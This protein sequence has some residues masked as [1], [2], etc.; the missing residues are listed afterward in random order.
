MSR[1]G[2]GREKN[3]SPELKFSPP[4]GKI[5]ENL[6]KFDNSGNGNEK[7]GNW[8]SIGDS[9]RSGLKFITAIMATVPRMMDESERIFD[10]S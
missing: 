5:G 2:K 7:G 3:L 8:L 9:R 1:R 4:R 6:S 10:A